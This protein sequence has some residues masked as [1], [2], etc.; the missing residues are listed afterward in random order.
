LTLRER[1]EGGGGGENRI[2]TNVILYTLHHILLERR[3]RG[4]YVWQSIQQAQCMNS[5][6]R[7]E[8][9]NLNT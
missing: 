4:G 3:N 2:V 6:T 8:E 9:I 1:G 7:R 5:K